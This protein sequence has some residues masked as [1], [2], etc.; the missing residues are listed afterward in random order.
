MLAPV[1]HRIFVWR[2]RRPLLASVRVDVLW[3]PPMPRRA[4]AGVEPIAEGSRVV[5]VTDTGKGGE[6]DV[7][8]GASPMV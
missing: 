8:D 3:Q 7:F 1:F 2:E 5:F 4:Q 6:L